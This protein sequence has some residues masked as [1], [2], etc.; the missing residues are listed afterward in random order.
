MRADREIPRAGEDVAQVSAAALRSPADQETM[1][2]YAAAA[3][4]LMVVATL[5]SVT[6]EDVSVVWCPFAC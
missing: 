5:Y 1:L 6:G 3:M 4:A 2:C